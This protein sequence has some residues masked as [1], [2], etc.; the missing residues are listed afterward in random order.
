MKLKRIE[1]CSLEMVREYKDVFTKNSAS[2]HG[3]FF[4]EKFDDLNKWA[5]YERLVE[6]GQTEWIPSTTLF[7]VD[8]SLGKIVGIISIRHNIEFEP[9]NKYYGH[10]GY[11]IHPDF[12]RLGHAKA[13]LEKTL[14]ICK[15]LGI[16]RVLI[17]C[18]KD[19]VA[20]YK[21]IEANGGVLESIVDVP[22]DTPHRRYWINL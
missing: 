19:N 18:V 11:S 15:E 1:E 8:E 5:E 3:G 13:M 10:I 9:L 14:P 21:T 22:N 4:L 16:E 2:I 12:R 17:T 7:Y 20:S 6:L